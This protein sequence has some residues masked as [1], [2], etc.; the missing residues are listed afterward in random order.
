[1][2]A[3]DTIQQIAD[4]YDRTLY[5]SNAFWYTAP[6]HLRATAYLYGVDTTSGGKCQGA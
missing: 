6:A 3:D 5:T 2:T 1:M 4:S